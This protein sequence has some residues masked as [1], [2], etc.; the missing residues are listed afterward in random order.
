MQ[1]RIARRSFLGMAAGA[2][3][4]APLSIGKAI[5]ATPAEL[6]IQR[7]GWAG[8]RLQ[9]QNATLFID[10]LADASVWGPSLKDGLAPIGDVVGDATVLVTHRHPDHY[11][12]GTVAQ[13]L[14]HGGTFAYPSAMTPTSPLPANVRSRPSP[15]WEPQILG[16]FTATPVPASDGYGDPQVSW[17]VSIGSR[18]IFHGGDTLWHGS[19]WRIARQHAP[20]DV[21]FLPINGA[22]FGWQK[23]ASDA[24]AVLTPEQAMDAATILRAKMIVPIH[25]G[26]R[27]EEGYHEVED[28]VGRLRRAEKSEGPK[29]QILQPGEWLAPLPL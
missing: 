8:V 6:R 2:A 11:D 23:P 12:P 18:R 5:A 29:V 22:S 27:G 14:Q 3:T 9:T 28:P 20:F 19:W 26:V 16:D 4:L 10:P 24:P 7:L 25:F 1:I 21:A 15:T 13:I 17:V